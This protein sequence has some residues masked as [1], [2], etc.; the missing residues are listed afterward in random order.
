MKQQHNNREKARTILQQLYEIEQMGLRSYELQVG[1]DAKGRR[2][3]RR[4]VI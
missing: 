2:R 1:Y 4:I 3:I